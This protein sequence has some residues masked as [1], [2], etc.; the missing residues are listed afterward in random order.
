MATARIHSPRVSTGCFSGTAQRPASKAPENHFIVD[1][2]FSF[3]TGSDNHKIF[4]VHNNGLLYALK[5]RGLTGIA[6]SVRANSPGE[7]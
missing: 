6:P 4:L 2:P 3:E 1:R 7:I 5:A